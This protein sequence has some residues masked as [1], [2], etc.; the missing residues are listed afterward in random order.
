MVEV[1]GVGVDEPSGDRSPPWSA[2][3]VSRVSMQTL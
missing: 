2:A 1:G 3:A